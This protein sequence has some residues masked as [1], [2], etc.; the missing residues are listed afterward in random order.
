MYR[1]TEEIRMW[2][3]V[4]HSTVDSNICSLCLCFTSLLRHVLIPLLWLTH[5]F[6]LLKHTRLNWRSDG[7]NSLTY[8]VLSK[9]LEPLYTNLSVNI[10][11]DPHPP[12]KKSALPKNASYPAARPKDREKDQGTLGW[13]STQVTKLEGHL[14][15]TNTSSDVGQKDVV[16]QEIVWCHRCSP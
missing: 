11:E 13:Q 2:Q 9:E 16:K 10:G 1:K 12:P 8:E 5:R 14:K 3:I 15:V 6:D 7:L 4:F